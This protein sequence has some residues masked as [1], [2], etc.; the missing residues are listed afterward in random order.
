[1][2][3]MTSHPLECLG[4][5]DSFGARK[6]PLSRL[7]R[8]RLNQKP[9]EQ[10]GATP[11]VPLPPP[12]LELH[13][14]PRIMDSKFSDYSG[15]QSL[16]GNNAS[17]RANT[18]II[19]EFRNPGAQNR[20]ASGSKPGASRRNPSMRLKGVVSSSARCLVIRTYAGH[21]R[22]R[23]GYN[24]WWKEW[25]SSPTPRVEPIRPKLSREGLG[26]EMETGTGQHTCRSSQLAAN[27]PPFS[28]RGRDTGDPLGLGGARVC[29]SM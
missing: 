25:F 12:F 7:H 23:T 4:F 9:V 13:N 18:A 20:I 21:Y 24:S 14:I 19:R 11:T 15:A 26:P 6:C 10:R 1:M 16:P 17:V 22:F 27:A 3:R 28:L 2:T 29:F 8:T 5:L